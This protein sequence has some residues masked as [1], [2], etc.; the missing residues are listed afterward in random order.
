VLSP[1]LDKLAIVADAETEPIIRSLEASGITSLRGLAEALNGRGVRTAR[2][3]HWYA[4]TVKQVL[5]EATPKASPG[6]PH[7]A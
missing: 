7:H 6:A 3:D 5:A 1:V 4:Q 2:G